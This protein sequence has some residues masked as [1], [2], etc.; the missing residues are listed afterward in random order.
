MKPLPPLATAPYFPG[1]GS[2]RIK[3]LCE[4]PEIQKNNKSPRRKKTSRNGGYIH[5]IVTR[6][7]AETA[8]EFFAFCK[9]YQ[10]NP[11][12][13]IRSNVKG[14]LR[15]KKKTESN[16]SREEAM[17]EIIECHPWLE[18]MLPPGR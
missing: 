16:V 12:E 11:S 14:W 15:K 18:E 10:F 9:K 4:M 17:E 13:V 5:I 7:F 3:E 8:T 6:D 1:D 2:F